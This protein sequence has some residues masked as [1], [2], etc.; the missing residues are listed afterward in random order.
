MKPTQNLVL[1]RYYYLVIAQLL[2]EAPDALRGAKYRRESQERNPKDLCLDFAPFRSYFVTF[3]GASVE[4]LAPVWCTRA[5]C[6]RETGI[7]SQRDFRGTCARATSHQFDVAI[8]MP[9]DLGSQHDLTRIES[10]HP[11]S[12]FVGMNGTFGPHEPAA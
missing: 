9:L 10:P 8:T 11:T 1:A 7:K 3:V 6:N 4:L 5:H 2:S 12:P